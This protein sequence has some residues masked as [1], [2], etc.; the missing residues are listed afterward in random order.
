[1]SRH[2]DILPLRSVTRDGTMIGVTAV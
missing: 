1:M 2:V